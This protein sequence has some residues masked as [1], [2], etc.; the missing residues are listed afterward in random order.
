MKPKWKIPD[1]RRPNSDPARGLDIYRTFDSRSCGLLF[2]DRLFLLRDRTAVLGSR[3]Q[4]RT[5][6]LRSPELGEV[7]GVR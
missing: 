1:Y 5:L 7:P 3:S 6:A 2:G 4:I